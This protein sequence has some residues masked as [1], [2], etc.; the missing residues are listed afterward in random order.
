MSCVIHVSRVTSYVYNLLYRVWG[1]VRWVF[2]KVGDY[3]A[4]A[5][6]SVELVVEHTKGG[7]AWGKEHY[8]ARGGS[9]PSSAHGLRKVAVPAQDGCACRTQLPLHQGG[10]IGVVGVDL[11]QDHAFPGQAKQPDKNVLR[12]EDREQ[13]LVEK[14]HA[15]KAYDARRSRQYLRRCGV[16]DR[17]ARKGVESRERLGRYRWVVERT[18]AWLGRSRRLTIRYERRAEIHQAFLSLGCALICWDFLQRI[19]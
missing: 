6:A 18:L 14:L 19:C 1:T 8:I 13:R 16:A 4:E 2:H 3:G 15:D 7:G 5:F 12:L 9:Q 17:I 11:V 10:H